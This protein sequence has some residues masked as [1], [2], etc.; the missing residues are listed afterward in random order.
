MCNARRTAG[1]IVR[2]ATV[3]DLLAR[4]RSAIEQDESF[5]YDVAAETGQMVD[6]VKHM[7]WFVKAVANWL[8]DNTGKWSRLPRFGD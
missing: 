3:D 1:R 4:A 7:P 5:I 8:I 2:A 6:N